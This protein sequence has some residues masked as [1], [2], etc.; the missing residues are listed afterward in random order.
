MVTFQPGTRD[1]FDLYLHAY[2]AANE[3]YNAAHGAAMIDMTSVAANI[4]HAEADDITYEAKA[5]GVNDAEAVFA[6]NTTEAEGV[7]TPIEAGVAVNAAAVEGAVAANEHAEV[8]NDSKATSPA[9]AEIAPEVPEEIEA[10]DVADDYNNA[11]SV[12]IRQG[13]QGHPIKRNIC[14][15]LNGQGLLRHKRLL[16]FL[17]IFATTFV[18]LYFCFGVT[19]K[20]SFLINR[21]SI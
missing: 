19:S 4:T 18:F 3:A 12:T 16:Q 1:N 7:V 15:W 20:K 10:A 21:F 2:Y 5:A 14:V 9:K 6:S 11:E 17:A 8:S 13:N